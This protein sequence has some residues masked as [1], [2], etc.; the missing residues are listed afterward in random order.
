MKLPWPIDAAGKK[1]NAVQGISCPSNCSCPRNCSRI[2]A[3][4]GDFRQRRRS[5]RRLPRPLLWA[6]CLGV[7][8]APWWLAALQWVVGLWLLAMDPRWL[9]LLDLRLAPVNAVLSQMNTK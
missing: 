6:R 4:I 5:S 9:D 1:E 2:D 8:L 7:L 3:A